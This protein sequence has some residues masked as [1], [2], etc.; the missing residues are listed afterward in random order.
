METEPKPEIS[1]DGICRWNLQIPAG[2]LKEVIFHWT[3]TADKDSGDLLDL[4]K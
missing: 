2:V 3:A 1:S 4:L